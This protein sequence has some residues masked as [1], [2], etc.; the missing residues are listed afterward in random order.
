[1]CIIFEVVNCTAMPYTE[2]KIYGKKRHPMNEKKKIRLIACDMDSTLLK[3]D[4]TISEK[5]LS[6]IR[7]AKERK[8]RFTICSGRIPTMLEYYMK[9][10]ELDTPAVTTN[11]AVIWDA[12]CGKPLDSSPMDKEE[13]F[14]VME[15]CAA[16]HLDYC[17]L[18]LGASFF[19]P[20][21]VRRK[22]FE[23]YN[24]IAAEGGFHTMELK[25]F[26]R[27]HAC[28]RNLDVYKMLI[29]E[30]HPGDTG[31]ALTFLKTLKKTG[32]TSSDPGLLDLSGRGVSKGYGLKRLAEI[33]GIPQEEICAF[34]DYYNDIS[35]LNYAGFP[36]AMKNGCDEIKSIASVITDSN[37]EDGVEKAVRRYIF[38]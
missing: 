37:E 36:I 17:A 18:T 16:H 2:L 30:V 38:P 14:A 20:D 33:L 1:M 23:Q 21:S 24:R 27:D 6:M 13:T 28:V 34:G 22:R 11:G 4:K 5:T 12:Q 32:F 9:I 19:S 8:I 25:T 7:E 26:D 29:Y 3:D 35:M 31:T 15:F 10:L